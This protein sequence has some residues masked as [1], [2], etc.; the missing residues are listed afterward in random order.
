MFIS[1]LSYSLELLVDVTRVREYLFGRYLW[2]FGWNAM[3][4]KKAKVKRKRWRHQEETI[5]RYRKWSRSM[6]IH[7]CLNT[8]CTW[9]SCA[10]NKSNLISRLKE[11]RT[12]KSCIKL[13]FSA[14]RESAIT[15]VGN[16]L[17][18]K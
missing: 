13:G 15:F 4:W 6:S 17:L 8:R 14:D 12:I 1:S 5:L 11:K 2:V 7:T 3:T 18:I 16:V 9:V 10:T